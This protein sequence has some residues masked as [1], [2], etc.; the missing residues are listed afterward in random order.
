MVGSRQHHP[1]VSAS[2]PGEGGAELMGRILEA[3][4]AGGVF[5]AVFI[6][7]PMAASAADQDTRPVP[8][9]A[10]PTTLD[11]VKFSA[12]VDLYGI[13]QIFEQLLRVGPDGKTQNWL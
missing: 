6:G 11:P 13:N 12:G 10:E 2:G 8:C 1:E 9:A 4:L 5:G 7:A 3:A